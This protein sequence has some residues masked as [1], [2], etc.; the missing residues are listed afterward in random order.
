M[1]DTAMTTPAALAA[2]AIA[3]SIAAG[4]LPQA[5]DRAAPP[6]PGPT[7]SLTLP[8]IEKRQ[9]SN[10]LPVWIVEL[11]EVPVAQ[12][13]LIVRAGAASDPAGKEGLASLTAAML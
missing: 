12:V 13:D 8:A 2:V 6:K 10:G 4:A 1:P 11:H 9:L 3:A 5:P 7:P